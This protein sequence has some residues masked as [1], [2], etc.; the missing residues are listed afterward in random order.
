MAATTQ[1]KTESDITART[2][3]KTESEDKKEQDQECENENEYEYENEH[4]H[5]REREYEHEQEYRHQSPTESSGH[6]Q[7]KEKTLFLGNLFLGFTFFDTKC[8]YTYHIIDSIHFNDCGSY[9]L[10]PLGNLCAITIILIIFYD[11]YITILD[12]LTVSSYVLSALHW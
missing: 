9:H 1:L 8:S 4:E 7:K 12:K 5:E 3:L 11:Q 10:E 6:T 2:Q